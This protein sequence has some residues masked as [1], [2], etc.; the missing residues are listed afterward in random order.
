MKS[1]VYASVVPKVS[2]AHKGKI[3]NYTV[4]LPLLQ[5]Y[6]IRTTNSRTMSPAE[7]FYSTLYVYVCDHLFHT[8]SRTRTLHTR[9]IYFCSINP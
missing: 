7:R 1:V 3:V 4:L 2:Q 6:Y 9:T 8:H 5:H